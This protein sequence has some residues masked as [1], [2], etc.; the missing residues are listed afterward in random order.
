[1]SAIADMS[2]ADDAAR[3]AFERYYNRPPRWIASAPGRVNLIGEYTDFNGGFVLPMAIEARTA[4]AAVPNE[5]ERIVLHSE[6]VCE[7]TTIDLSQPLKP[8][9]RG[10][11]T[12]YFRGVV[13]GFLNAGIR[14]RGFDA[15]VS[16]EVPLGAGLSSSAALETAA[17]T[18][19]EAITGVTLEPLRKVL[20]CQSAEHSFA[21]VPC[22]IMDPY[23]CSLGRTDHALLLDCRSNEPLWL[24]LDDPGVAVL[25]IN[26]NVR[27][28]LSK[29]EYALRRKACEEAAR[30]MK[31][32]S[33]RE[34]NMELLEMTDMD[35]RARRCARHV[36]GEIARTERAAQCIRRSDWGRFGQLLDASHNSLKDDFDVSCEELDA[37]IA[38]ARG[39]GPAGGVFGARLTGGGFGGC[40]VALIDATRQAD[41]ARA[42]EAAYR[43]N[44]GIKATL[45]VSRPSQGARVNKV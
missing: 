35:E 25:V 32:L 9:I 36:I 8:E 16:S 6:A 14:P 34:A 42:I 21:G 18:L 37:V 44:T 11:W 30:A 31:V 38:A 28:Q 3:E 27:H 19:L 13:A 12:N 22:G 43:R 15:L 45:F 40:V 1:M 39:I 20:L 4:I 10:R 23:I 2:R 33:L 41:I 24:A 26:T 29:G 17:A 5:S 7:T